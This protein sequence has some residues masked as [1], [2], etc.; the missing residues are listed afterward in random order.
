[1]YDNRWST[2]YCEKQVLT[3]W[4]RDVHF[5]MFHSKFLSPEEDLS[6]FFLN[7]HACT[8]HINLNN[9][10]ETLTKSLRYL[11]YHHLYLVVDNVLYVTISK[12][13]Y[14]NGLIQSYNTIILMVFE[15]LENNCKQNIVIKYSSHVFH[16]S[17][18]LI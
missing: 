8:K 13:I 10:I 12:K 15:L 3:L 1:M 16:F 6:C 7:D 4:V 5:G 18:S 9:F 14:V 11:Y 2:A 17:H